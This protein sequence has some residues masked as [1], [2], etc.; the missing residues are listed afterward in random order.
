MEWYHEM[1]GFE[2]VHINPAPDGPNYAVLYRN[3][4]SIHLVR[5]D[6]AEHGVRSPAQAQFWIDGELDELFE[7]VTSKGAV[8]LEPPQDRPWKHRDF[9]VRDPDKNI[10]WVSLP[11][12]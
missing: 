2:P 10:V 5:Q 9:M 12:G 11:L 7:G 8:V 1:F 6:E 4:V 3:G